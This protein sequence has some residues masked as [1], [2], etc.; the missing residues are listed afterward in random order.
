MRQLEEEFNR[1][2]E[3]QFRLEFVY[4]NEEQKKELRIINRDLT[5]AERSKVKKKVDDLAGVLE[6]LETGDVQIEDLP[7]NLRERLRAIL[8]K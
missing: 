4:P 6:S 2:K 8:A 1:I 5:R 3:H 7:E